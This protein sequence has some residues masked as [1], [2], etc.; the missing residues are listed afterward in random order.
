[1]ATVEPGQEL[2][3]GVRKGHVPATVVERLGEHGT[4]E[5]ASAGQ[6]SVV[7]PVDGQELLAG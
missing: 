7:Q 4:I 1:M 5:L 2:F 6:A 3:L